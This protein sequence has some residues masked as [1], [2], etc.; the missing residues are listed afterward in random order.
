MVHS[1][2]FENVSEQFLQTFL[3]DSYVPLG[4][5]QLGGFILGLVHS[6]H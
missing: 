5:K 4:H 3:S 6:V 1:T 2:Q